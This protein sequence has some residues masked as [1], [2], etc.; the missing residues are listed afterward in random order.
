MMEDRSTQISQF[1]LTKNYNLSKQ[2]MF[3]QQT[4]NIKKKESLKPLVPPSCMVA[5]VRDIVNKHFCAIYTYSKFSNMV[6]TPSRMNMDIDGCNIVG[7]NQR[8][9]SISHSNM[10]S[11]SASIVLNVSSKP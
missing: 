3:D 9:R 1:R 11:K 4:K 5:P 10:T 6:K 7:K 8:E 2:I